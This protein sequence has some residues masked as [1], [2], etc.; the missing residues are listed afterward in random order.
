MK[1]KFRISI[2]DIG[3]QFDSTRFFEKSVN[4][5]MKDAK[6]CIKIKCRRNYG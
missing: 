3:I 4:W 2:F 6:I 5:W 1:A